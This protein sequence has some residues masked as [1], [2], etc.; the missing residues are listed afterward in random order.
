M[1]P[2]R[3]VAVLDMRR[4]GQGDRWRLLAVVAAASEGEADRV[5]VRHT[6]LERLVDGGIELARAITL[7]QP[8]QGGR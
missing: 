2:H 7:Q 8:E 5:R 6:P 1:R 4:Q 3:L